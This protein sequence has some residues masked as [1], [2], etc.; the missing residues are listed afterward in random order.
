MVVIITQTKIN[1]PLHLQSDLC[2]QLT[3]MRTKII[4]SLLYN[5]YYFNMY[6]EP[7]FDSSSLI[8]MKGRTNRR[9]DGWTDGP[10]IL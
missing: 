9:T 3:K 10:S 8:L 5:Y 2:F 4:S 1:Y 6:G 7:S